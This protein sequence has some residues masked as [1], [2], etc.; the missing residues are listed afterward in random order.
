MP[1][2]TDEINLAGVRFTFCRPLDASLL[3]PA[4]HPFLAH[5]EPADLACAVTG[6]APNDALS[7]M[8]VAPDEPWSF[9]LFGDRFEVMRRDREG[10][11]VWRITGPVPFESATVQWH[12]TRFSQ[13]YGTF[14]RTLGQGIGLVLL[15]LRLLTHRGFVLHALAADLD[16]EGILCA[17]VSGRGKSTLARLL[18][19][20]GATVLSDE[21]PVVRQWSLPGGDAAPPRSGFRV[22][23][24][25]WP[26]S[27]NMA[28]NAWAPLRRLYFLE[29]G[30]TNQIT[31]LD[32]SAAL[33]RLIP[34]VTVPWQAPSLL[35]PVLET[36][37]ALVTR[38]PCAVLAFR[39]EADAVAAIRGDLTAGR[40]TPCAAGR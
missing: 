17:G 32:P 15:T 22:Y 23:G 34:V 40:E 8:R 18:D 36:I 10:H 1:D 7:R 28:R 38:I 29:H 6:M 30:S 4:F 27:A 19:A 35:D 33:R 31:P 3:S 16:G 20:A 24:S 26:S 13:R 39:P 37:G 2:G 14:E 25:P 5:A 11:V 9:Q 12:P 21:R